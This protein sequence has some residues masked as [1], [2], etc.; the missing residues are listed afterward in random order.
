MADI[1]L[2]DLVVK[3]N[4]FFFPSESQRW[5]IIDFT[6]SLIQS[7]LKS[8]KKKMPNGSNM[9]HTSNEYRIGAAYLPTKNPMLAGYQYKLDFLYF[10]SHWIHCNCLGFGFFWRR[11]KSYKCI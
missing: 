7:L 5:P 8:I 11:K 9:Y 3:L 2:G 6:K 10:Q 4:G 1:D